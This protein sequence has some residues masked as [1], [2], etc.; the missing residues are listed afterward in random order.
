MNSIMLH[1]APP[2][3]SYYTAKRLT[4]IMFIV[5]IIYLQT[6][7]AACFA[8]LRSARMLK[9]CLGA[10]LTVQRA[11]SVRLPIV[12]RC[13]LARSQ[14]TCPSAMTLT[15]QAAPLRPHHQPTYRCPHQAAL[16][17]D[18][19]PRPPARPEAL[20]PGAPRRAGAFV[21]TGDEIHPRKRFSM[22]KLTLCCRTR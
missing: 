22:M 1:A 6:I 17:P 5:C 8:V 7:I 19:N 4:I 21:K 14:V 11:C 13:L 20:C 3:A 2:Y 18:K 15:A 10:R 12:Q 16:C 9:A